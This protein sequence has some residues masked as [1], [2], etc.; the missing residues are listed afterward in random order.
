MYEYTTTHPGGFVNPAPLGAGDL[1]EADF[2][3][4]PHIS[5][6]GVIE[7]TAIKT[8]SFRMAIIHGFTRDTPLQSAGVGLDITLETMKS[9]GAGRTRVRSFR[10]GASY[11]RKPDAATDCLS[12]ITNRLH[13]FH[14]SGCSTKTLWRPVFRN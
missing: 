8:P 3:P 6:M 12:T 4:A 13:E 11:G 9:L 1:A 2:W 10:L 7:P 5:D 14:P